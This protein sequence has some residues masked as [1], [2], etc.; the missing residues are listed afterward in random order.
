MTAVNEPSSAHKAMR[1]D[2]KMIADTLAGAKRIRQGGTTYLPQY[3][4][5]SLAEY[6]RRLAST[7]WRPEFE[8]ALRSIVAKPFANEVAFQGDVSEQMKALAED[9]DG[10]GNNLNAFARS[11]F[12]DGVALGMAGILV[13]YPAMSPGMTLAQERASGARPYWV[14]IRADEILA[15]YTEN[16]GGQEIVSHLRLI[17]TV[18]ERDGYGEKAVTRVRVFEPGRWELWES[19]GKNNM[20]MVGEGVVTLPYVPFAMFWA[21]ERSGPQY[22]RPPLLNLAGMQIELYQALSRQ[23]E[24]LTFAG[25]PMLAAKGLARPDDGEMAVGPKRV[26]FAPPGADGVQTG[27]EFIQPAA[28]NITEIRAHVESIVADMRRLGMQPMLPKTGGVSATASA[29][30]AA[31][32]HSAVEAWAVALKDTLEQAFVYTAQWLKANE[33]P[34]VHVHT[35]FG[36]GE[37]GDTE[38]RELSAARARRDISLPTYWDEMRRRGILGPQFDPD[39]ENER[40]AE[41]APD[42]EEMLAA[43]LPSQRTGDPAAQQEREAPTQSARG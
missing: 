37:F 27:W 30:D 35:D 39:E 40:L 24:I 6:Q 13:D 9:I 8:D 32:A 42:E 19:D 7:P 43:M 11:V 34:E 33:A 20:A 26:L 12:S 22:V 29:V 28:A 31:K 10:R 14:P 36:A 41:E 17:E 2:W 4:A 21:G 3:P 18:V 23:D 1:D 25:S 15:L 38:I 5:E 16:V